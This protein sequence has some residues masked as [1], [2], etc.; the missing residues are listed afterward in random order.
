M[1]IRFTI[2]WAYL[3]LTADWTGCGIV[4]CCSSAVAF[5]LVTDIA[6][7]EMQQR[8]PVEIQL[9]CHRISTALGPPS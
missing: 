6:A 5:G 1:H 2:R 3:W 4:A 9:R 8:I 7:P